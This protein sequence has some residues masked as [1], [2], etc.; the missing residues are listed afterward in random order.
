MKIF[1]VS[2]IREADHFTI[3]NEPIRSIDLMERAANECVKWITDRFT[4]THDLKIICGTGNNGG[5]GLAIARLLSEQNYNVE[6]LV[7]N[8]SQSRSQDFLINYEK[9]KLIS[10]SNSK[11]SID[12]INS[13]QSFR[14]AYVLNKQSVTIDS[15]I[16]SGLSRSVADFPAE[17]IECINESSHT[18]ISIDI[19]SGLYC[20][21]LNKSDDHI[22]HADHTLTFQFPKLSFMFPETEQYVGELS[23]LDIGLH[24]GYIDQ[25]KTHNYFTTKKEV[26]S[27]LKKRSKTSHKGNYGHSLIVAGSY[28]KIG[29]AVLASKA[30]LRS[31]TGLLTVHIP[32]CGYDIV[33]TSIPEAMVNADSEM[34]FIGDNIS[35]NNFDAVGIGPG[36]GN[37]K[38]TETL[39]K[40]LIQNSLVP[41]VFDADAI[42]IISENKTWLSFIPA[43]SI[44]TPHP[45]EFERLAG[46]SSTSAERLK[47]QREFSIKYAVFVILKGFRTAI[48]TP[49]GSVYFNSTG[50]PGMAK[51]GSGDALTGIVTS[52]M[53][54]NYSSLEA[55]IAGVYIHGSAGD[56]AVRQKS[57]ESML[58]SDLIDH[59]P[60]AFRSLKSRD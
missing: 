35:L 58:A 4:I 43:D 11:C 7:I 37:E 23:I 19:P 13:I 8:Y 1:S 60:D 36:I 6:V 27:F 59:I 47:L 41:I 40:L 20:D 9:F 15:L 51:A 46:K 39:L 2:Q 45:K 42:N 24:H 21:E 54:Q 48:S 10:Q 22:I 44:L 25:T 34:N 50:N 28:G 53:A 32:K 52:L 16:G 3:L 57:E 30:C 55:C 5:D 38:K 29:A 12:E 31:G 14:T 18:T 26:A 33:Q 49:D 56:H 17:V